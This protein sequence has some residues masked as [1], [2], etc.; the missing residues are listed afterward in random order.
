MIE[1][2]QSSISKDWLRW[3]AWSA[4]VAV[5]IANREERLVVDGRG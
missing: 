5:A 3:P 2:A 1:E 4:I